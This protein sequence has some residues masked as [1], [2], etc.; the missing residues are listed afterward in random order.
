[1]P[2][3][4]SAL[5]RCRVVVPLMLLAACAHCVATQAPAPMHA[6]QT[7]APLA[8]Y[9][10]PTPPQ[11]AARLTMQGN[12]P[13]GA[14]YV[15]DV[16]ADTATC[17]GHQRV[18]GSTGPLD[19]SPT[20]LATERWQTLEVT[21]TEP[22]ARR[23]CTVRVSFTPRHGRAYQLTPRAADN[24][25]NALVFDTTD[26]QAPQLESSFRYRV[27]STE[28]CVPLARA[29]TPI[30]GPLPQESVSVQDLPTNPDT[31]ALSSNRAHRNATT[32]GPSPDEAVTNED[33]NGLTGH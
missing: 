14:F 18:G 32:G 6:P 15:V 29:E 21:F 4:R 8:R 25:C 3:F 13:L 17:R 27:S 26:P 5:A 22:L 28:P 19:P 1:M 11:D 20:A 9:V 16:L 30:R 7:E 2:A 23:T 24:H 12:V 33:L 31:D 10:M